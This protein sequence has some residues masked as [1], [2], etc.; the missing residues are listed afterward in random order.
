MSVLGIIT[1]EVF[2]L[3]FA[4][5][6][7][8]DPDVSK[9]TVIE[10]QHSAHLIEMLEAEGERSVVRI[11]HIAS[12]RPEHSE[13][14]EVVVRVFEIGLHKRSDYLRSALSSAAREMSPVVDALLI[15][16]GLCGGALKNWDELLEGDIPVFIPMDNQHPADDCVGMLIGGRECYYDEQHKAAG[17]FFITPGWSRHWRKIFKEHLLG[18][19][20]ERAKRVLGHCERCLLIHTP[21]MGEDEMRSNVDEFAQTLNAR[22]EVCQGTMSILT[23]AWESAKAYLKAPGDL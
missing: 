3:E 19:S 1:C 21:V 23:Q 20:T 12:F 4:C 6:L 22:I 5:L 11:P 18:L 2:E 7:A 14:L 17:T 10:D 16:Y 13:K 15:G 9:V 8:D